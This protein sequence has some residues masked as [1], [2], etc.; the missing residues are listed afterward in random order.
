MKFW[1]DPKCIDNDQGIHIITW[2]GQLFLGFNLNTD[3]VIEFN[4]FTHIYLFKTIYWT[5]FRD[6][7]PQGYSRFSNQWP[8]NLSGVVLEEMGAKRAALR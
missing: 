2:K 5:I 7:D 3:F 4:F 1:I 8:R 6:K